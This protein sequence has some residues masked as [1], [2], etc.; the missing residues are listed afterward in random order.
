MP[1]QDERGTLHSSSAEST[2]YAAGTVVQKK[3]HQGRQRAV[4]LAVQEKMCQVRKR[5][6]GVKVPPATMQLEP[7]EEGFCRVPPAEGS[8]AACELRVG[9][10]N[11]R[12]MCC[13]IRIPP[14]SFNMP[15]TLGIGKAL[16]I[17]ILSAERS[18]LVAE[19]SNVRMDLMSGDHI[20]VREG[21]EYCLRNTS[22]TE[23]AHLKMILMMQPGQPEGGGDGNRVEGSKVC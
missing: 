1:I 6:I 2:S 3:M 19:L 22:V 15:E 5:S 23:Y 21:C 16:V 10:D 14:R 4:G 20:L 9:S 11:G 13:D 7:L 18:T 12:W 8:N 17:C